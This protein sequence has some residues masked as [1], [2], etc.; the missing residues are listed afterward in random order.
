MNN[1]TPRER[2]RAS[3]RSGPSELGRGRSRVDPVPNATTSALD[4]LHARGHLADIDR[5]FGAFTAEIDGGRESEV[6][7]AAA[8]ASAH[9]R[10]GH[11]CLAME[12]VAGRDWPDADGVALPA[13]RPWLDAL[14]AS[15]AVNAGGAG[16]RRPLVL[17][18]RGRLFLERLWTVERQVAYRIRELARPVEAGLAPAPERLEAALDRF[19]PRPAPSERPRAAARAAA[20]RRL[21]VVTGGPGTG[22][23]TTVAGNCRPAH[24]ARTRR[25][26]AHRAGRPHRQG[27]GT[28]PGI[29]ARA[30]PRAGVRDPRSCGFH[31]GGEH[32]APPAAGAP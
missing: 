15:P 21:C 11:T 5:H 7:L 17:D 26:R 3:D 4:D 23:T 29:G 19:F 14:A 20:E 18:G 24:R 31:G 22:K 27:G 32:R 13:L 30:L 6:A 10:E 9:A 2:H 1:D 28:P 16:E 25:A 12:A 8:L